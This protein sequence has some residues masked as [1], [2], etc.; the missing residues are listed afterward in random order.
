[1]TT[2]ILDFETTGL[3]PYH[4]DIIDIGCK[5]LNEN[6]SFNSLVKPKSKR[7]LDEYISNLTGIS[8]KM[9]VK[10]GIE[11]ITAYQNFINFIIEHSKLN[12]PTYIVSHNGDSFDFIF[13]RKIIHELVTKKYIGSN[14]IDSLQFKYIDTI[15]FAK[16]LLENRYKFSLNS[17]CKTYNIEQPDAHRAYPDVISLECLYNTLCIIYGKQVNNSITPELVYK[18]I[19]LL[20]YS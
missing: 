14:I 12:E 19:H 4:Q 10:E 6:I 17:L 2:F 15:P 16:R 13:F 8:N 9:I 5:V 7:L 3:N 1:M 18:Y 20:D 11:Y